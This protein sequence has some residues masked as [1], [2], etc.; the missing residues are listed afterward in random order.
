[1]HD[2]AEHYE[3]RT[4]VVTGGNG[5]LASALSAALKKTSARVIVVSRR[6]LAAAAGVESLKADVRTKDCW[7][8]IVERADVVFH[9]AGNTSVYSAAKDPADSL[10]STVLPLNHLTAVAQETRRRPRVLYASTATVYGLTE[11]LPVAEDRDTNPITTYDLHK[12]FAER[13][14]ALASRQGILEGVS[15]RLSNVYGPSRAA[16]SADDRGILNKITRLAV[17]GS[18]LRLF[19][20]GNYLRDYVYIDDVV[21]AFLVTGAQDGIAGRSFNV[22]S[23]AG[24]TLRDAF[25]LVI[26]RAARAT[27]MRSRLHTVPWPEDADAI[28]F[29]NFT[30]DIGAMS[31][32]CGWKP[33]VPLTEGVDR[34]IEDFA[35]REIHG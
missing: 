3:G 8:E 14:L 16:S 27:G 10:T 7:R 12:L 6:D 25:Q 9:L 32:A 17:E 11:K 5:Y 15:L 24:L 26:E 28:E 23:G 19:G 33:L 18:D 20:D 4:V 1:M 2:F 34:L 22:A 13:Q 35:A 21:R 31:S 30:A 29:R